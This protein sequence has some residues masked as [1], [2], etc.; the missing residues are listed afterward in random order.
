M[1]FHTEMMSEKEEI[2]IV[3]EFNEKGLFK[4]KTEN[5][6]RKL[7]MKS[8]SIGVLCQSCESAKWQW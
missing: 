5:G 1:H 3:Y 6:P 8:I 7:S 4:T 2:H